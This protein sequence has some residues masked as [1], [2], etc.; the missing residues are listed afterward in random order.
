[1]KNKE[2]A[3]KT[4]LHNLELGTSIDG[5]C[6]KAGVSKST[7]Y[8][9]KRKDEEFKEKIEEA[10]AKSEANWVYTLN[11]IVNDED[12]PAHVRVNGLKFLL[13]NRHPTKWASTRVIELEHD[14]SMDIFRTMIEQTNEVKS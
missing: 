1:M 12:T 11:D 3:I 13:V 6:S 4:I 10:M 8:N 2:Q 14:D 9:W 5:S 7:Y